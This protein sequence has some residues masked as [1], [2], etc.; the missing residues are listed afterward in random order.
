MTQ[1]QRPELERAVRAGILSAE[2]ADRLAE[3]FGAPPA[4]DCRRGGA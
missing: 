4:A 3:F 1:L 2:Q